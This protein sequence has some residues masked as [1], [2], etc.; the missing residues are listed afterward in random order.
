VPHVGPGPG[1]T[2][3]PLDLDA[4]ARTDAVFSAL[5]DST[6]RQLF[7]AVAQRAPVTATELAADLPITRQAVAKHLTLLADAGLVVPRRVGRETQYEARPAN[8][9]EVTRWVA[10]TGAA[11]DE[12]LVRLRRRLDGDP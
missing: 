10:E 3:L 7:R 5:A 11:W 2:E 12:R 6:R 1:L 9:D 4:E 8:L